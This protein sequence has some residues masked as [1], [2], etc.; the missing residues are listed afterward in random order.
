ML[1]NFLHGRRLCQ[2]DY[3]NILSNSKSVL[4][5]SSPM[6]I[7]STRVF[8]A[9]GSGAVGLFSEESNA[10]IIFENKV[11]FLSFNKI[12][13]LIKKIYQVKNTSTSSLF[14]QI[15]DNG[16]ICIENEHDWENR[17]LKFKEE[18]SKI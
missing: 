7:I 9:L 3:F 10:Q 6:G 18:V 14:Q 11:H 1:S 17:V 4:H 8:E 13:D 15:A 5:T 16:R 2:T 12:D